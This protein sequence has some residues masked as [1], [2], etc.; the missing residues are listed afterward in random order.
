M[1]ILYISIISLFL[2]TG[3]IFGAAEPHP[4]SDSEGIWKGEIET[5]GPFYMPRKDE[6]LVRLLGFPITCD[7][8]CL[9]LV[10]FHGEFTS[11]TARKLKFSAHSAAARIDPVEI[12]KDEI[13]GNLYGYD[14]ESISLLEQLKDSGYGEPSE[15]R[16]IIDERKIIRKKDFAKNFYYLKYPIIRR[17]I[18]TRRLYEVNY[19]CNL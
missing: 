10:R 4:T 11:M 19:S 3:N 17:V 5:E 16:K 2:I 14:P 18:P 8:Y 9:F 15:K 6:V 13:Q 12:E 1:K 7:S